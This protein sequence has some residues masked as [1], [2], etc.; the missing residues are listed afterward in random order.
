M[1]SILADILALLF[2]LEAP[3]CTGSASARRHGER[4]DRAYLIVAGGDACRSKTAPYRSPMPAMNKST[5]G[6]P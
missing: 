3:A 6:N 2:A 5:A 4:R 1:G